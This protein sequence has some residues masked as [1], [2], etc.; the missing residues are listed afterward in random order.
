MDDRAL[1]QRTKL[2]VVIAHRDPFFSAGLACHLGHLPEFEPVVSGLELGASIADGHSGDVV[3]ADY[4]SGL[5]VLRSNSRWR[6]RVVILT[7][8]DSEANICHAVKHGVRG[9][10]LLGCGVADVATAIRKVHQ[11]G[12]AMA[13]LLA[14]RIAEWAGWEKLTPCELDILRLLIAGLA[15]KEIALESSRKIETVKTHVKTI[16]RKLNARNRT[17][18]VT[19]AWRRGIL[20]EEVSARMR[21]RASLR[22]EWGGNCGM[23]MRKPSADLIAAGLSPLAPQHAAIAAARVMLA[24]I[25]RLSTERLDFA[26]ESTLSGQT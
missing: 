5:R 16:L 22:R 15:N 18:A 2:T 7:E 20:P 19:V 26:F 9:Y 4:D 10:L 1:Q 23:S 8:R 25:D 6:D 11:G 24:E 17:H 21:S 14:S 3:I 12:L 13:P